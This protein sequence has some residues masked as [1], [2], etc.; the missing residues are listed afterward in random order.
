MKKCILQPTQEGSV[1]LSMSHFRL[2]WLG[3]GG[4]WEREREEKQVRKR[5][6][7]LKY[8]GW[9]IYKTSKCEQRP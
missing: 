1:N 3:D 7:S 6:E 2:S 8:W 4:T 9:S 5:V